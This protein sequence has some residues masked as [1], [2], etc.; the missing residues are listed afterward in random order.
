MHDDVVSVKQRPKWL[1]MMGTAHEQG[2]PRIQ[3]E[4]VLKPAAPPNCICSAHFWIDLTRIANG[5][6]GGWVALAW[7][8]DPKLLLFFA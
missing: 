7:M 1:D 6:E 5:G 3:L 4:Y 8:S 2:G